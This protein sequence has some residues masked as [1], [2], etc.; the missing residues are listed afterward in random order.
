M[1]IVTGHRFTQ[2][3]RQRQKDRTIISRTSFQV[4]REVLIGAET[5]AERR[6]ARVNALGIHLEMWFR[7]RARNYGFDLSGV[8][9]GA[10]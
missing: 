2:R 1:T 8:G 9:A 4:S 6:W 10:G 3:P 5:S 7:S